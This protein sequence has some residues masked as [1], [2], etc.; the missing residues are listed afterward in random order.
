METFP[1]RVYTH[2]EVK[3]AK[4]FVD[5]GYRHRLRIKGDAVFNEK[6]RQA[7]K[8]VKTAGY[9]DFLRT[10]IRCIVEIDGL[11]QL[12]ESEASI[13]ANK[14]AVENPV[15][16]ASLFVQKAHH[17]REYLEGK[18]YYGGMAEKRSVE[19]RMEFLKRLMEKSRKKDVR[20]ECEKL[21]KIWN[22]SFLVY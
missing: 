16:A 8:L 9:Y 4:E 1:E 17:M 22:E 10:Y 6:V 20:N 11:T 13:W 12:R 3:K 18:L 5:K 21:L 2:E 7:L 14:Y 19:A 15:D